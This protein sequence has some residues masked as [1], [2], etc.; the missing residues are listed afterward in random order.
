MEK[1][2]IFKKPQKDYPIS[3]GKR[4]LPFRYRVRYYPY[5]RKGKILP[6]CS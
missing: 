4:I 1:I 3:V 6:V 5:P 2:I